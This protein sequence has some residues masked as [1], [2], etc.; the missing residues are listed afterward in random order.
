MPSR[1]K[2]SSSQSLARS[3]Q[4]KR[5][6]AKGHR[7]LLHLALPQEIV[8]G[9]DT[10]LWLRVTGASKSV[11]AIRGGKHQIYDEAVAAFLLKFERRPCKGLKVRLANQGWRTLWVSTPL[12]ERCKRVAEREGIAVGR[13]VSYALTSFIQGIM[14]PDWHAFRQ[15]AHER[16]TALLSAKH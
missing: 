11:E 12:V 8:D 4:S 10:L 15:E 3:V 6:A 5:I 2:N 14:R 1:R 9:L 13:V 7:T 16:A